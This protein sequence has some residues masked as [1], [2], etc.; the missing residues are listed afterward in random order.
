M[1]IIK[2]IYAR[3]YYMEGNLVLGDILVGEVEKVI[4]KPAIVLDFLDKV[5]E[6]KIKYKTKWILFR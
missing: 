4:S 2:L 6:Y 3:D 5:R 1:L